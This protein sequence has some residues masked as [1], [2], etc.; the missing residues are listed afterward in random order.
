MAGDPTLDLNQTIVSAVNAR[1]EAEVAKALAGDEMI[2][3]LVTAALMQPVEVGR[4]FDHKKVP[5]LT[6]VLQKA[7]Q[8][9]TETAIKKMIEQHIDDIEY[10]VRG[11]LLRDL[12]RIA[13]V[14]TE[15][16]TTAAGK[17]YGFDVKIDLKMP[18]P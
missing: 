17:T 15:S 8:T 16:L 5:F 14:L 18:R 3:R 13:G 4:S 7:I 11:A 9:A 1:I 6:S 2:G 10:A 12:D